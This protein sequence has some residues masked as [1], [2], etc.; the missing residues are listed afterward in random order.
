MS[1]SSQRQAWRTQATSTSTAVACAIASTPHWTTFRL[2]S[3][4][5]SCVCTCP[6]SLDVGSQIP[7]PNRP[8]S[9]FPFYLASP[10]LRRART[11]A[12]LLAGCRPALA[13]TTCVCR[14][15]TRCHTLLLKLVDHSCL[16]NDCDR[17]TTQLRGQT[18]LVLP[19]RRKLKVPKAITARALFQ[20]MKKVSA[21]ECANLV[22]MNCDAWFSGVSRKMMA[23]CYDDMMLRYPDVDSAVA[24][25]KYLSIKLPGS[26]AEDGLTARTV[27][28]SHLFTEANLLTFVKH[29]MGKGIGDQIFAGKKSTASSRSKRGSE[30]DTAH[31]KKKKRRSGGSNS[32]SGS[33]LS[34]TPTSASSPAAK[35]PTVDTTGLSND[36]TDVLK[37]LAQLHRAHN[38]F[39][40]GLTVPPAP[41]AAVSSILRDCEG[42]PD[43]N[44]QFMLHVFGLIP[45]QV[46][47]VPDTTT[48]Q[49]ITVEYLTRNTMHHQQALRH[50]NPERHSCDS[51]NGEDVNF[52][53]DLDH[54]YDDGSFAQLEEMAVNDK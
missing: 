44:N 43:A 25:L 11:R 32:G 9:Q 26:D 29:I 23:V 8:L 28:G 42:R 35:G 20:V 7:I 33:P 18:S 14:H 40:G 1:C 38:V 4:I 10:S 3:Q 15:A 39:K 34:P 46:L 12:H 6:C 52:D 41:T 48:A 37:Q 47:Q 2:A 36:Q 54:N 24:A 27:S 50:Y 16:A 13:T 22:R 17:D 30:Q 31:D 51:S 49:A 53:Y 5:S 45:N 19:G 21:V